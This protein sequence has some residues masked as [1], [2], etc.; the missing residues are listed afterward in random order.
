MPARQFGSVNYD[1]AGKCWRAQWE[2]EHGKRKTKTGFKTKTD[3]RKW[4]NT[5]TDRVEQ[6]RQGNTAIHPT[7]MPTLRAF[8]SLFLDQYIFD[9]QI[10]R[11]RLK[12]AVD[13]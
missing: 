7:D 11:D 12:Y 6:A 4:L 9:D 3:A 1:K 5:E 10:L 8:V 2:N 13:G